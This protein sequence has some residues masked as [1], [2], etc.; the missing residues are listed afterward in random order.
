MQTTSISRVYDSPPEK[1]GAVQY[2]NGSY[3]STQEAQL[4]QLDGIIADPD[5]GITRPCKAF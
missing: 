1:C 3:Y 2:S 4:D 5:V